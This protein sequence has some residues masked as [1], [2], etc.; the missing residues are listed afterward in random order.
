M[1]ISLPDARQL[2]DE[3]L[4]AFRLRA[5]H[6]CQLGFTELD[7]SQVLGVAH[8][9]VCRWWSAFVA[10]G[11][12]ALPS[13]RSGR[14]SGAGAALS[15]FQAHHIQALLDDNANP[16]KLGIAA[17]LW[18]RR[19]VAELIRRPFGID[20]AVRTV[21]AYLRRW[22]YTCKKPRRHARRQDPE[23]VRVW[24][25]ET[26][27]AIARRAA[28]EGAAI[29]WCDE[30]GV[31]ADAHPARGYARRGM[32]AQLE[33]PDRHIRV[34]QVS[35]ISNAGAVRFM[36]FTRTMTAAVLLEF[37]G[38][39]L[40]GTTGKIFLILDRLT[41][42]QDGAI[43]AWVAAHADRLELFYLPRRAP[44]RN[45][46]EYLNQDVKG[47]VHAE[48][49]PANKGELRSQL[50]GFMRKLLHLPEHVKSYFQHPCV[51]YAAGV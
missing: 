22:G 10:G 45:P 48:G 51:Q 5:I 24:L 42:H 6:A 31:A 17:P 12:D 43:E 50:Q 16:E 49:L 7:V 19:A 29:Y 26:Y 13:D 4:E 35:A 20:L 1:A 39:L 44:E 36:T 14:P 41:A 33:V 47:N 34:N 40:R 2:S 28:D 46:D 11:T 27:P 37:L 21:G 8:E 9:T 15:E 18:T 30:R 25:E 32:P 3:T 38:R 23:E